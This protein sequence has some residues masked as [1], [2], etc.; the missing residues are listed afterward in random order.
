M[1]PNLVATKLASSRGKDTILRGLSRAELRER[2][3][4]S[5]QNFLGRSLSTGKAM[6]DL[7]LLP[8]DYL[9]GVPPSYDTLEFAS[10][11]SS[12]K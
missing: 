12:P 10:G 3:L 2:D 7:Q 11:S 9:P 1:L 6:I 4:P 8:E 5:T